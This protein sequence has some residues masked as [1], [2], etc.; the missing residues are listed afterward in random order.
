MVGK[1]TVNNSTDQTSGQYWLKLPF[2][3]QYWSIQKSV[4]Y[5]VTLHTR[6]CLK[7]INLQ[8]ISEHY[9]DGTSWLDIIV[10]DSHLQHHH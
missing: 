10:S 7:G 5:K 1:K 2:T 4:F 9:I 6:T 8:K 3:G